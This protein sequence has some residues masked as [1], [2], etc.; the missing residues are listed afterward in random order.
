MCCGTS[1]SGYT[2]SFSTHHVHKTLSGFLTKFLLHTA[3]Y[4]CRGNLSIHSPEINEY[5]LPSICQKKLADLAFPP[6]NPQNL[7]RVF[8]KK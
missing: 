5:Q 1:E 4:N 6:S 8:I 3:Q 7:K 2:P